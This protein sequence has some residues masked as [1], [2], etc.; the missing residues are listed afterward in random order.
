M[1]VL[2]KNVV[3]KLLEWG[4]DLVG[5]APAQRLN[6]APEGHRPTDFMPE[7]KSVISIGLH[8]F[9]SEMEKS[10]SYDFIYVGAVPAEEGDRVEDENE[11][12]PVFAKGGK[13]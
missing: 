12:S 13:R 5:I 1:D 8:L 7:C 11:R 9:R 4:A 3:D 2:T 10:M 6:K